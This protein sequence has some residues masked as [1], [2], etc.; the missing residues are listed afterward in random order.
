[1]YGYGILNNHV[2]TL[3]ATAMRGGSAPSP[4]LT[5][6]FAVYKA[7]SNANDSLATYNGI[8][9]GGLTYSGGKSGNA[10]TFNGT[11]AYVS[12]P[13]NS[14]NFTG[15]FSYSFW[16]KSTDLTAGGGIIVGNVQFPRTP[17][18]FAHGYEIGTG[19]GKCYFFFRSGTNIQYNHYTTNVVNNGNWNHIVVT[20]DPN[21]L[22]TGAKIYVNGTLNIQ[23]NTLGLVT[24]IGYSSPMKACIGA[25]NHSGSA[26]NPLPS[27][28]S[29]DELNAWS[30]ELTSTE[31][32]EL[33]NAGTGKFY[34]Y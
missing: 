12:L 17:Y 16:I 9:Q 21:D 11:N 15:K 8:A 5:S 2:P 3:K 29:I 28:T 33:Y 13:D 19:S 30:K 18:G 26:V 7:E 4:L 31:V 14:L 23:A 24:P 25:R 27:G 20:Y 22:T 34:P 32:T 1:M 6:L 10:F